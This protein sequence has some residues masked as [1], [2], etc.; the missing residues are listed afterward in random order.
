MKLYPDI[1]NDKT[2]RPHLE[3]S[4][5]KAEDAYFLCEYGTTDNDTASR[6]QCERLEKEIDSFSQEVQRLVTLEHRE[7]MEACRFERPP[8]VDGRV[9]GDL[10]ASCRQTLA[11]R[12][13]KF[14]ALARQGYRARQSM[15]NLMHVHKGICKTKYHWL[16]KEW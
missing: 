6:L 2:D 4:L 10:Q 1:G 9:V 8:F 16:G 3:Q 13:P 12:D 14:A 5:K 11:D 7:R 15:T